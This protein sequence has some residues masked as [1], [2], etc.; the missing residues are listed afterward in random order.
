[1]SELASFTRN[2]SDRWHDEVPGARWFRADLHVHTMDDHPSSNL[3]LPPGITGDP[4]DPATQRVYARALLRGAIAK[5]VEILGLTP[6]SVMSG[7]TSATWHI[8]QMWNDENDDDGVPFRDKVYAVFPGFECNLQEAS[9]GIHLSFLFDPE[10]GLETYVDVF[11]EA[12]GAL[13]AWDGDKLRLSNKTPLEVFRSLQALHKRL[14]ADWGYLTLAPHAFSERGLF[15]LKSEMLRWFPHN[16]ISALELKDDQLPEDAQKSKPW[17]EQGMKEYSHCLFHS[18]DAYS[19]ASIGNRFTLAKLASP[20]IEALRQAFLSAESRL[21]IAF[22]RNAGTTLVPRSD[23]PEAFPISRPW[24][25]KVA[26]TGGTSFFATA[27]VSAGAEVQQTFTLN[28]DF[29]CLIGGRMSGKSTFLDGMR[30]WCGHALPSDE[31]IKKDVLGRARDR[32]LSGGASVEPQVHSPCN[33]TSPWKDRWPAI[34][35][36][37]RELE[38]A[39]N[40]QAT[41]RYVLYRLV[42]AETAGLIQREHLIE[43]LDEELLRLATEVESAE[44]DLATAA[45]D[46]QQAKES[47]DALKRFEEAGIGKLTETQADQAKIEILIEKLSTQADTISTL[48]SEV[49]NLG[50][51]SLVNSD[52]RAAMDKSPGESKYDD[53]AAKYKETIALLRQTLSEM[54]SRADKTLEMSKANVGTIRTQ[55]QQAVIEAGGRAEDLNEFDSLVEAAADYEGTLSRLTNSERAVSRA[56]RNWAS[57]HLKR[58]RLVNEQRQAMERVAAAIET[59][60]PDRIRVQ[61][62]RDGVPT[63]LR[64]WIS[65]LKE[66]GITRWWN[67]REGNEKVVTSPETIRRSFNAKK[68]SS[69]GMSP[70]VSLTFSSVMTPSRRLQLATLRNEDRYLVQSKVGK[71]PEQFRDIDGLSGG[72]QASVLLSLILE[73]EDSTPLVVDQPEDELD[74]AYLFEVFLPAL[75]RMKGRRQVIFATHDPNIVVNGDADNVLFL[76]ADFNNGRV[77]T[78]GGIEEPEVKQAILDTLDGGKEAFELRKKKYGF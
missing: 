2:H 57:S 42:P 53:L 68:L 47:K 74:K 55:V 23:L 34:F 56:L 10:I 11:T 43:A 54:R 73:T 71:G 69:M 49:D 78:Q 61:V 25:H 16:F 15:C 51:G 1:V 50:V 75:R 5:G 4:K 32:F 29:N 64:E 24:L 52:L 40:D 20:R 8:V 76:Q 36:S 21:R 13:P 26:I 66:T 30:V 38:K 46:H 67:Q 60:F 44:R 41:R 45:Q 31:A 37:Q 77:A 27:G 9:E 12:M 70:V 28:P 65:S 22:C 14:S 3:K 18:S 39:V 33:P 62:Q 59:R 17:L 72:A 7:A 6:H 48:E 35:Y 58:L 19:V 63:T